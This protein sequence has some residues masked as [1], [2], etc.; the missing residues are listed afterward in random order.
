MSS[1]PANGA[2]DL[3]LS[4]ASE[5]AN[6]DLQIEEEV[7]ALFDLMGPRLLGY[8]VSFGIPVQDGEDVVQETFLAL[9]QHLRRRGSRKNLRGW[10]YQ[11]THNLALKRR[12][13]KASEAVAFDETYVAGLESGPNPEEL[14][15][16]SERHA[17]LQSALKALSP[18]DQ[19]CLRL[20]ADGLRYREISKVLGI[21]VGSVAASLARSFARLERAEGR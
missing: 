1:F 19:S 20:R 18:V 8:A 11:V 10:L 6:G 4:P 17:R 21:S 12:F 2:I 7:L 15:L 5:S 16:F 3:Y 14:V 13:G 9:F